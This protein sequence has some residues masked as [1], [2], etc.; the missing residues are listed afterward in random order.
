MDITLDDR[1][2]SFQQISQRKLVEI[3]DIIPGKKDF[4]I[5]QKL[6]KIL[7]TFVGVTVL[8]K[9]GVDKIFKFAQGLKYT[10]VQRIYVVT[11]NLVTCQNVFDEIK[12]ELCQTP[13][14][15][16]HMLIAPFIPIAV[17]D[18]IEE[19]GLYGLVTLRP[20]AWEFIRIDGNV[21]SLETPLFTDLYY[22]KNT[23]LL[24]S[25]AR[26]LWTLRM[27]LGIPNFTFALGKHSQH[28][29][30]MIS[31]M[32]ESLGSPS[33][34]DEFGA[35]ILMDRSQDFVSTLLTPVTYLGLLSEVVEIN[36][37]S[38]SLGTSQTIL[39]PIK[40]Q[41]Y[42]EVRDKHFSNAFPT[43]HTKAKSLKS[44][45]ESMQSMK[46]AEM[47]HYVQTTLQKTAK[48]KQQL[49]FHI[50]A[51]EA[52]VNALASK[53][54]T[55]HFIETSILECTRRAECLAYI[56]Q[57]I[58]DNPHRGLRLLSLL[59]LT[60]DGI[61]N[62]EL[63]TIQKTHLHAHGYQHI[64]LFYKLE[65]ANLLSTRA[66][67]MLTRLPN[68]TSK[69]TVNTRR[70]KLLPNSS[71]PLDLKG[72]TC[73]SYVFNGSYIPLIAQILNI[74]NSQITDPKSFE[75]LTNTVGCTFKGI[76]GPIHPQC[77]V[78]CVIGGI[79]FSEISACRLIEKSAGI[80]LVLTSDCILTGNKIMENLENA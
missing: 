53:F 35:L 11:C 68:R 56:L 41:V 18:L 71:K 76:Q 42:G 4:I 40:D 65:T 26:S 30:K 5:E 67:N 78:I 17:N 31:A 2:N 63:L 25:L 58:D 73:P 24:P 13:G 52:T 9:Y 75:E 37:G 34:K 38:A 14:L 39:D 57:N 16:H 33:T 51:C 21:L 66:E 59:S 49:E 28:I 72:P 80:R 64:P 62:D 22:H 10:N 46:L 20:L 8:K 12:A 29:L 69:W 50:S 45:Q 79:T 27:V 36:I 74:L 43:L 3:L 44:E 7:D 32:D 54:E 70:L 48:I 15:S 61:T 55:L 77:I 6:M 47:K 60:S 19:N 23:G 1:L